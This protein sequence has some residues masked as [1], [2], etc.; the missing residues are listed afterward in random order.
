MRRKPLLSLFWLL[1]SLVAGLQ[2]QAAGAASEVDG[3]SAEQWLD[4]LSHSYREIDYRGVFTHELGSRLQSLRILHAV[5]DGKEYERLEY[6]DGEDRSV[7]RHEHSLNCIHQGHRLRRA[8][9]T[10]A[11]DT[12]YPALSDYY[13]LSVAPGERIAGR[14][15]VELRVEPQDVYRFAHRLMLDRETGL[16]LQSELL[17]GRD[18]TLERF[19]FSTIEIGAAIERAEF[20]GEAYQAQHRVAVTDGQSHTMPWHPGWVPQ[21]FELAGGDGSGANDMQTYTDGMA[22]FS[23]FL[24][25]RP[26]QAEGQARRGATVAY[27]RPVVIEGAPWSITVVGEI[28]QLT[29]RRIA[30]SI[31]IGAAP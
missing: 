31:V 25:A 8:V 26:M 29:A 23:I 1:L 18:R 10:T 5:I 9:E 3:L 16:V 12:R 14:D 22:V 13:T 2:A 4:R 21:G 27:G 28:P 17:D 7:A 24:E 6:L 11:S 20:A 30:N 15:V 19:R